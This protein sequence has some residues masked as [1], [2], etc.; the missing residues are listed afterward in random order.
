MSRWAALIHH[1]LGYPGL[2]YSVNNLALAGAH[3]TKKHI[4]ATTGHER[5]AQDV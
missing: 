2:T 1:D 5:P 4:R 3:F